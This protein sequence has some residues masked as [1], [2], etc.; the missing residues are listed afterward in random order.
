M[1][2]QKIQGKTF[3]QFKMLLLTAGTDYMIERTVLID[4]APK[5]QL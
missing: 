4:Y 2:F 1:A 5:M 3:I